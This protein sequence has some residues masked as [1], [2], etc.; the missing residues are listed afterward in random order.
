[1][2]FEQLF[3]NM[4]FSYT[5]VQYTYIPYDSDFLKICSLWHRGLILCQV[6]L[7]P[8]TSYLF[9]GKCM[10]ECS[11]LRMRV[12][13]CYFCI[14]WTMQNEYVGSHSLALFFYMHSAE[15][16]HRS[17]KSMQGGSVYLIENPAKEQMLCW[18]CMDAGAA[19]VILLPCV[20]SLHRS[21]NYTLLETNKFLLSC[22]VGSSILRMKEQN[23]KWVKVKDGEV[24]IYC[25]I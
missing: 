16:L 12:C 18:I 8:G 9:P 13:R 4:I 25:L 22:N 17:S 14:Y 2:D 11:F 5:N 23:Q 15:H 7:F 3:Q 1:M 10:N 20:H 24:M 19:G 21:D 6:H